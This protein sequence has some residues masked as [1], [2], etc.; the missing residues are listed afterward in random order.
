MEASA[1]VNDKRR[2]LE[3][4]RIK[5]IL[6]M[7]SQLLYFLNNIK[8]TNQELLRE[9]CGYFAPDEQDVDKIAKL[10]RDKIFAS[11]PANKHP[12]KNSDEIR[13]RGRI[14]SVQ[15][16]QTISQKIESCFQNFFL[17]LQRRL[18]ST[19]SACGEPKGHTLIMLINMR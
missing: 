4:T 17:P 13:G 10:I 15:S 6:L 14:V 8:T 9:I 5:G 3:S 18:V 19:R 7:I 16:S 1:L 2:E 11:R 12:G